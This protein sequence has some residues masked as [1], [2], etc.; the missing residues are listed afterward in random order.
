MKLILITYYSS[1]ETGT[2]ENYY[3]FEADDIETSKIQLFEL[4]TEKRKEVEKWNLNHNN[5]HL[6]YKSIP[7]N[8]KLKAVQSE[9][10]A[11]KLKQSYR[12]CPKNEINWF[13]HKI[14]YSE[15]LSEYNDFDIFEL[16]EW[17]KTKTIIRK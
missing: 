3:G 5:L 7:D 2:I 15:I 16:N 1:E 17:W 10:Y 11:E 6:E 4:A 13:G 8:H 12:T 14:E 9:I